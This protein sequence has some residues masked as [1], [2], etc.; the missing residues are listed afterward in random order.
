MRTVLLLA[1]AGSAIAAFHA[2]KAA[3]LRTAS[4]VDGNWF[5]LTRFR[6]PGEPQAVSLQSPV[7]SANATR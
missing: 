5:L 1:E 2:G 3:G 4:L 6:L 7:P